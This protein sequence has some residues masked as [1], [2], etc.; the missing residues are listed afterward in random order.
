MKI[1]FTILL[2]LVF[3][4]LSF[5]TLAQENTLGTSTELKVETPILTPDGNEIPTFHATDLSQVF[6]QAEKYYKA[7]QAWNKLK[8]EPKTGFICTK[9]KCAERE[10]K[11]YLILDKGN[12]TISRCEGEIC[13]KYAAD[14]NQTG[15]FYNVQTEGPIG[16]LIRILG[17]SRYKEITT[18]GLDAYIA[19]GNCEPIT[20]DKIN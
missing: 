11:T 16:T 19:N 9:W 15:V 20:D 5:P 13:D 10:T 17:D 12:S 4:F 3:S 1:K 14:F 6:E 2:S 8:C 18:V 7:G